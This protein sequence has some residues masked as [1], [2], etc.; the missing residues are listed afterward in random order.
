MHQ[1][2]CPGVFH[3]GQGGSIVNV[4][5]VEAEIIRTNDL[6]YGTASGALATFRQKVGTALALHGI[7]AIRVNCVSLGTSDTSRYDISYVGTPE[8]LFGT[9]GW[10]P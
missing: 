9:N 8:P 3:Q 2:R 4:I 6:A 10:T 5:S 1:Y 7:R